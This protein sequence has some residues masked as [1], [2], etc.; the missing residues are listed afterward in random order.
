M[1]L[2]KAWIIA[3]KDLRIFRKNKTVLRSVILFP[4]IV[5]IV[6]PLVVHFAG[7][8]HGGITLS[9]LPTIL[10]AFSFFF[11]IGAVYLPT[12]IASYSL[13]GEKS[14]EEP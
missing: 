9:R 10:N 4:L 11:I 1:R 12:F 3:A 5:S 14:R 13:V 6:L 2:S 8:S 7:P